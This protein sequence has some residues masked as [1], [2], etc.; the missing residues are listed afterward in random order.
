MKL[1]TTKNTFHLNLHKEW[2]YKTLTNEKKEEYRDITPYWTKRFEHLFPL[3][4]KGETYHPILETLTFSNG[5]AKDRKQFEKEFTGI[6][7]GYGNPEWGATPGVK[8]Y[9]LSHGKVLQTNFTMELSSSAL[10]SLNK[11]SSIKKQS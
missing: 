1:F 4:F 7:I 10:K 9:I 2:F 3:E 8:Q 11:L 5:Y 6:R